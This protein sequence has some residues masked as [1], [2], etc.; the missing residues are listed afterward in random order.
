MANDYMLATLELEAAAV[1]S[2]QR[3]AFDVVA[4]IG[5]DPDPDESN[6]VARLSMSS[7]IAL[8][9]SNAIEAR[10]HVIVPVLHG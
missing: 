5:Y 4:L 7:G 6:H 2:M 10:K 8:N 1:R 3:H 9:P